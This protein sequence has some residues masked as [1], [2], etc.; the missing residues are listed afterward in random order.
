MSQTV[1][2][3]GAMRASIQKAKA[4]KQRQTFTV[5]GPK[6]EPEKPDKNVFV[7]SYAGSNYHMM[8]QKQDGYQITLKLEEAD[9]VQFCGGA[10]VAPSLY[11]QLCHKETN[12]DLTRDRHE[13]M[14]FRYCL[15]ENIP[16]AGICRGAQFLNV[17]CGGDMYQHVDNHRSGN[18]E[19]YDLIEEKRF[20][21]TSTHHQ[22]MCPGKG[23]LVIAEAYQSTMREKMFKAGRQLQLPRGE[24]EGD[25][26]IVYYPFVRAFCFQGHPEFTG[27]PDLADRYFEY[28]DN[29]LFYDGWEECELLIT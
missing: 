27:A 18:H 16:M 26:E 1:V 3:L 24:G 28:L 20:T 12:Y 15:Q 11:G 9:L 29:Y 17:M 22:M 10:D 5:L 14:I 6:P 19:V 13:A 7:V 23:A 2:D 8:F 25:P 21:T 4:K